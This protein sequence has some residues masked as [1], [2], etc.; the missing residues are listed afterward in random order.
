ML[1]IY[2][3]FQNILL[4]NSLENEQRSNKK[5]ENNAAVWRIYFRKIKFNTS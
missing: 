3:Y 1:K 4:K 2:S 5:Y